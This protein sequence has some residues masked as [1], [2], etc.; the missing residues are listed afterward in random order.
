MVAAKVSMWDFLKPDCSV[1]DD[2][3][4]NISLSFKLSQISL[5]VSTE[6]IDKICNDID[7]A[8]EQSERIKGLK[9]FMGIVH[10]TADEI[11]CQKT[12]GN[13]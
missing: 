1:I 6:K 2:D 3:L 7:H 9:A 11:E 4:S 10:K 8:I 12:R 5:A 13:T